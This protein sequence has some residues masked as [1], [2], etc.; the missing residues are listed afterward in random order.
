MDP[1]YESLELVKRA[2]ELA[3]KL[4]IADER[5]YIITNKVNNKSNKILM[6]GLKERNLGANVVGSVRFDSKI[7]EAS[8]FGRP[9]IEYEGR[10]VR[11]VEEIANKIVRI[12][13]RYGFI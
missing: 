13:I 6:E 11:D 1:S 12:P 5:V 9:M 2:K 4:G 3:V 8:M 10:A 7:E